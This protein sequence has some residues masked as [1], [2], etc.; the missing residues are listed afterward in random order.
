M[1][2]IEIPSPNAPS[3]YV[4]ANGYIPFQRDRLAQMRQDGGK[5]VSAGRQITGELHGDPTPFRDLAAPDGGAETGLLAHACGDLALDVSWK[6][7]HPLQNREHGPLPEQRAQP[8]SRVQCWDV[9][10]V[11]IL[12][13]GD[14]HRYNE[15]ASPTPRQQRGLF[16]HHSSGNGEPQ[17]HEDIIPACFLMRPVGRIAAHYL[18]PTAL[19]LRLKKSEC[20]CCCGWACPTPNVGSLGR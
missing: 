3:P 18:T 10:I 9:L 8:R 6:S 11:R 20:D 19:I 17:D 1:L 5:A 2:V 13:H 7:F 4:N 14:P 12:N 15:P 16:R